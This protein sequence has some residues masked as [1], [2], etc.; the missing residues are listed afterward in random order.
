MTTK[1]LFAA[2]LLLASCSACAQNIWRCGPDGRSY[3]AEPC[4]GGREL[5]AA[6]ARSERDLADAESVAAREAALARQL[7]AERRQRE[8]E[9]LPSAA[10]GIAHSKNELSPS[11]PRKLLLL[12]PKLRPHPRWEAHRDAGAESGRTTLRASR[13]KPD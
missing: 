4:A 5:P 13:Q 10:A 8:A 11:A 2:V 6:P 7:R 12:P 3:Q 1:P 9:A